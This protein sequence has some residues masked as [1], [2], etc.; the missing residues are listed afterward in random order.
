MLRI[1]LFI[2][3]AIL[4]IPAPVRADEIGRD[5]VVLA[6]GG[7]IRGTLVTVEP[8]KEV[9]IIADGERRAIPWKDVASVERGKHV[10]PP[11]PPEPPAPPEPPSPP[12]QDALNPSDGK[13]GKAP[14]GVRIHIASDE[15][16]V[17]LL[18]NDGLSVIESRGTAQPF[19]ATPI[20]CTNP[21]DAVVDTT[22][23]SEFYFGGP[24]IVAS[25]AYFLHGQEGE[26]V[27]NVEAGSWPVRVGG[28]IATAGGGAAT[29]AG[30]TLLGLHFASGGTGVVGS[31]DSLAIGGFVTFPV[32]LVGLGAG[33]AMISLSST[34]V[35]WTRNGAPI[36]F[37]ADGLR[38]RF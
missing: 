7:T 12:V 25:D 5:E 32:G 34:D 27:A 19:I 31:D 6:N 4:V 21:C 29:L 13:E 14:K 35:T 23:G 8:D 18:R 28:I 15:P 11:E 17:Q 37:A 30:A 33:I 2:G 26:L 36:E 3:F 16:K 9:I 1:V 24:D 22:V 20:V 38:Y 10:P